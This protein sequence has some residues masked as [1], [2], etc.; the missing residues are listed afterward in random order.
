VISAV[1]VDRRAAMGATAA[2]MLD[3]GDA[4]A[5]A[6]GAATGSKTPAVDGAYSGLLEALRR[7]P[8]QLPCSYLY[9]AAGSEL[10]ERI[11]ELEEY[12]PFRTEQAMLRQH[13][14]EIVS[15]IAPGPSAFKI[16]HS[17]RTCSRWL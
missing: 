4:K 16:R 17:R 7:S 10:Y 15:Y 14:R 6:A 5:A 1:C 2:T 11:T 12:Y 13:A 3:A 9:D 8:K